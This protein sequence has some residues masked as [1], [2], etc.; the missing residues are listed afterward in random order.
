MPEGGRQQTPARRCFNPPAYDSLTETPKPISTP[1][2]VW[3]HA[4]AYCSTQAP[5]GKEPWTRLVSMEQVST[6]G[7]AGPAASSL[8]QNLPTTL[9]PF[10]ARKALGTVLRIACPQWR[11]LGPA[12]Q[13]G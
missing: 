5:K 12:G 11:E 2:L 13:S 1:M 9:L 8:T 10:T 6:Q 7:L 3:A 4:M